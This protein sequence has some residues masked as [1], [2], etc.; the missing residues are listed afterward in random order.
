[1]G[2]EAQGHPFKNKCI[3][4]RQL[5]QMTKLKKVEVRVGWTHE[6]YPDPKAKGSKLPESVQHVNKAKRGR[7]GKQK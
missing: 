2:N 4:I 1:M 5:K 6:F 7:C 3:S